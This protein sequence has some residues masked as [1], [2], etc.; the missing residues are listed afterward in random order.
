MP[1]LP[2][3]AALLLAATPVLADPAR[4]VVVELF[5]SQGCSS[6]PPADRLLTELS[7]T[8]QDVLPLAFHVTYWNQLGWKDP[9]SFEAATDRQRRYARLSDVGGIYTPQAVVDGR[10]DVVGSDGAGLRRAIA[11]AAA[12]VQALPLTVHRAGAELAIALPAG[13]GAGKVLVVGY[14]GEHRTQVARGE[15][16]GATLLESNIVRGLALAGEWQGRPAELHVAAP[17]GEHLA[18]IV[19]AAD[20]AILGAARVAGP[21]G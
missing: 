4:P 9:Y 3:L 11:A 2:I 18:V 1:R 19:Q 14:D 21:Q 12:R 6:C 17:A 7:R 15:N 13:T 5:T 10:Q 16:A 8:R 20:G